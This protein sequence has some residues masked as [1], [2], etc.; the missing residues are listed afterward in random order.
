MRMP[1]T[2]DYDG[3]RIRENLAGFWGS[4]PTSLWDGLVYEGFSS[5]VWVLLG[6]SNFPPLF[7]CL[8][9]VL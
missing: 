7:F 6:L 5:A 8:C 3:I 2:E 9:R 4:L 1:D